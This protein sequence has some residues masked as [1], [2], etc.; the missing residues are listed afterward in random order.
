[1]ADTISILDGSTFLVSDGRGDIEAT[2]DEHDLVGRD[3]C[4]HPMIDDPDPV[5]A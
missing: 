3:H 5:T 1:M 4:A 2:P